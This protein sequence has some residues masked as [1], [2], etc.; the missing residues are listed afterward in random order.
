[1]KECVCTL[2]YNLNNSKYYQFLKD[3][4]IPTIE[5]Y[6]NR[7]GKD[8]IILEPDFNRYNQVWNQLK[9]FDLLN[10]Y[11][12]IM[13][14]DGDHFI[15][16]EMNIDLFSLLSEDQIGMEIH[17][18]K[19]SKCKY[20]FSMLLISKKYKN[21]FMNEFPKVEFQS[22][23]NY[24]CMFDKIE[25]EN[26]NNLNIIRFPREECLLNQIIIKNNL[27]NKVIDLLSLAGRNLIG[28]LSTI[29]YNS[30][31]KDNETLIDFTIKQLLKKDKSLKNILKYYER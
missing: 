7:I 16:K 31:G 18:Y 28:H 23:Y 13:Y 22:D 30:K 26:L 19:I 12:R 20:V 21:L 8:F 17:P 27:Q 10:N 6:A 1:M 25:C 4:A 5:A 14:I 15:E 11:D 24:R 2:H 29:L 9:C 3:Y